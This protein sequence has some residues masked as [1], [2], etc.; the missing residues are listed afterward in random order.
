MMKCLGIFLMMAFLSACSHTQKIEVKPFSEEIHQFD[1]WNAKNSFPSQAILFVGSSSIRLW[2]TAKYFSKYPV[3]NRGFGGAHCSDV[4]SHYDVVIKP[5]Q[6]KMIF[7]YC[8]DN[9]IDAGEDV[10]EVFTE[11]KKLLQRIGDDFPNSKVV[12]IGIKSS[13]SR[14]N[15]WE[16]MSQLNQKIASYLS[17]KKG[18]DYLDLGKFLMDSN[19]RPKA[20]YFRE[21]KLHLSEEGYQ[22]WSDTLDKYLV[23]VAK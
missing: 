17:H 2:Q 8:G 6:A 20:K 10:D 23:G 14:R 7:I 16:Q 4:Y 11:V 21:D 5:Y 13:E 3:I 1:L 12:F 18:M 15:K 19:G 22:V 9:D